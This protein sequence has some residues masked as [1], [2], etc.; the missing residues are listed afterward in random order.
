[1]SLRS[2][3]EHVEALWEGV[4]DGTL[5]AIGSD[6]AQEPYRPDVPPGDVRALPYGLAGVEERLPFVL[7]E[8]QRRG[9]PLE[10]LV[11]LLCTGPARIFGLRGHK[12]AI[13]AGMDADLVIWDPEGESTGE[14]DPYSGRPVHG[15]IRLVVQRRAS[16]GM[17]APEPLAGPT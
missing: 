15:E 9:I 14:S 11:E 7:A 10:R 3:A 12:G 5:D 6:H 8:G 1:L 17:K 4:A 13:E 2:A 16:P